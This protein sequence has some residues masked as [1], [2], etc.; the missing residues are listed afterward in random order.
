MKRW[1]EMTREEKIA[2]LGD[3]IRWESPRAATIAYE[4]ELVRRLTA[5]LPLGREDRKW[6]RRIVKSRALS[7][8][9]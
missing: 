2:R 3:P 9:S 1:T 4:D 6:A 8:K 7:A 5:G